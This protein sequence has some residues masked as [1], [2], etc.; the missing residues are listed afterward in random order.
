M[1]FKDS[2]HYISIDNISRYCSFRSGIKF[3]KNG[4]NLKELELWTVERRLSR[5]FY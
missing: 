3:C 1:S 5:E 4:K 2:G